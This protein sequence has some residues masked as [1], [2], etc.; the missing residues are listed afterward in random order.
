[1]REVYFFILYFQNSIKKVTANWQFLAE[2]LNFLIYFF[3]DAKVYL[4]KNFIALPSLKGK[5]LLIL[6]E[7]MNI[8]LN[9]KLYA[10][11]N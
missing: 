7:Y 10:E 9:S 2:S 11:K 6:Y 1:M 8:F 4:C 3:E 5:I